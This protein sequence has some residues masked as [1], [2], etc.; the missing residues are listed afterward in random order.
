MRTNYLTAAMLL[1]TFILAHC[2]SDKAG[3]KNGGSAPMGAPMGAAPKST[4]SVWICNGKTS[5]K[6]HSDQDCKGLRN[7]THEL[8]EVSAQEAEDDY[9]RRPCKLC[10]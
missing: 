7:C 2:G 4:G 9:R 10:F 6:Y 1:L 3:N 8:I 5:K